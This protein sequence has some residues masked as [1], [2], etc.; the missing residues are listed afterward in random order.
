LLPIAEDFKKY[1]AVKPD[2]KLVLEAHADPRGSAEYNQALTER[3]AARVKGF[4]GEHGVPAQSVETRAFGAQAQLNA[5]QVKQSI[6]GD[7]AL[8]PGER[9][10]IIK[11]M[12][13]IVLAQNRRVDITLNA[14]GVE[15]QQSVRQFPFNGEDAL[16][17][18]GG[19]EKPQATPPPRKTGKKPAPRKAPAAKKKKAAQ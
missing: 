12:K 2:A 15:S 17:L 9:K 10:R 3:R 18:I 6:E 19:R 1:L 8:T 14:P 16:T 7:T 11:N 5:D 13:T 4:L